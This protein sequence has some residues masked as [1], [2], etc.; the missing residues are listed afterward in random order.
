MSSDPIVFE[1]TRNRQGIPYRLAIRGTSR[2]YYSTI[3][4]PRCNTTGLTVKV[5]TKIASLEKALAWI[6]THHSTN[7]PLGAAE[8]S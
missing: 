3:K 4:C 7:H 2:A 5:G 8:L 6:D 1:E